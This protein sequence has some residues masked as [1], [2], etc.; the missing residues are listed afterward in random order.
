LCTGSAKSNIT[1]KVKVINQL[2]TRRRRRLARTLM[3]MCQVQ[4]APALKSHQGQSE[5]MEYGTYVSR[6][7]LRVSQMAT[8]ISAR[9]SASAAL[10]G[11]ADGGID[12]GQQFTLAGLEPSQSPSS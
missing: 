2:R 9:A 1:C 8:R 5:Q 11:R 3:T 6:V 10:L 12:G 4:S 7:G